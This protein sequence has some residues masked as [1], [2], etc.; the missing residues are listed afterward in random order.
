MFY[1]IIQIRL[2]KFRSLPYIKIYM[3]QGLLQ[4]RTCIAYVQPLLA[5]AIA[6]TMKVLLF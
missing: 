2:N 6:Y 5:K 1:V 3:Y 4:E